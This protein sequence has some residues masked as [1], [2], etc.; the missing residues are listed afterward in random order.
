M[1]TLR[2]RQTWVSHG[3]K[4][5]GLACPTCSLL[6]SAGVSQRHGNIQ[7]ARGWPGLSN[8]LP[9]S[10]PRATPARLLLLHSASDSPTRHATH[11]FMPSRRYARSPRPASLTPIS[12]ANHAVNAALT[13]SFAASQSLGMGYRADAITAV[14]A[15]MTARFAHW[16]A[17]DCDRGGKD[18]EQQGGAT[19]PATAG[20]HCVCAAL[21]EHCLHRTSATE[22]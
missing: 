3:S 6:P 14:L 20:T 9:P 21:A 4:C 5:E 2:A 13:L 1:P 8:C 11:R 18:G 19:L 7:Q 16:N 17:G 22:P 12:A 10:Q 15:R